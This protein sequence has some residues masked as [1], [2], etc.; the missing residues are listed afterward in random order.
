M[1][2]TIVSIIKVAP[3]DALCKKPKLVIPKWWVSMGR[4]EGLMIV[5][6]RRERREMKHI[7]QRRFITLV[8]FWGG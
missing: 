8:V 7:A 1:C 4:T 6:K 2:P 5:P 3:L